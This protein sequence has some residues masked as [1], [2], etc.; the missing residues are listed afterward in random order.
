MDEQ[1]KISALAK[2]ARELNAA[3]ITWAVGASALL[4]LE[5]IVPTFN[6]LDL[7]IA[8]GQLAN[9]KNAMLAAG[10]TELPASPP[11]PGFSSAGFL[12][13][14]IDGVDFDLLE[15]FAVR[16]GSEVYTY[17]FHADRIGAVWDAAGVPVPLCPLADWFV[18]YQLMPGRQ[19][20]AKLIAQ[21]L[22]SHPRV[23]RRDWLH[24]WLEGRLPGNVREQTLRL[25]GKTA[26]D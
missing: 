16:S 9:A 1:E 7:L 25:F 12:E 18:L 22:L 14:R 5:G 21:Y 24:T 2:A 8:N 6:D 4:Y 15:G 19:K 13:F 10:A 23:E 3:G 20:K 26:F 17:S 11:N